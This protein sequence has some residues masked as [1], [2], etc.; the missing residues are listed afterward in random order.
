VT[1]PIETSAPGL[2]LPRGTSFWTEDSWVHEIARGPVPTYTREQLARTFYART[3]RWLSGQLQTL[4]I[5]DAQLG[6]VRSMAMRQGMR[7]RR[8]SLRNVE[9]L[10]HLLLA[11]H[12]IDGRRASAAITIVKATAVLHGW[13]QEIE[14][15]ERGRVL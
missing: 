1:R 11:A 5:V 6:H 4:S 2:V 15:K 3:G 10:T 14:R 8:Y 13:H 7:S 12:A 9:V